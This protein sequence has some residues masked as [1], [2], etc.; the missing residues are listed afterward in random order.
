MNSKKNG[1]F[2]R[3]TGTE[4]FRKKLNI[5][6]SGTF[7]KVRDTQKIEKHNI[8]EKPDIRKNR[9]HIRSLGHTFVVIYMRIFLVI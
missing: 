7:E 4:V 9:L 6:K 5:R 3:I 2:E 1:T 8:Q